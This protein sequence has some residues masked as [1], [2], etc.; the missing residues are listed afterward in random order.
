[1]AAALLNSSF[2][3]AFELDD[4]HAESPIHS[5]SVILPALFALVQHQS[6]DRAIT[7]SQLLL[8]AIVGYEVGPRI[9]LGL[10]GGDILS[11][12]W[13]SRAVFGPTTAAAAVSKAMGL[14]AEKIEEAVGM[15]CSQACGLL[16]LQY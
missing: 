13:H 8:A 14:N 2:T 6:R 11:W 9:G 4:H 12:G 7:D 5:S 10:S 3:Q 1:L 16:S 15:A